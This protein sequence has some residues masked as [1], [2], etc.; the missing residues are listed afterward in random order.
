MFHGI[1][2]RANDLGANPYLTFS[3]AACVELIC[4]IFTFKILQFDV[5]RK[6]YFVLML[7]CG[8]S[9]TAIYFSSK[10][11]KFRLS[12]FSWTYFNLII[13]ENLLLTVLSALIAKFSISAS[14]AIV[15]FYSSELFN[16]SLRARYLSN[17]SLMARVGS[18][19]APFIIGV[20]S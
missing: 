9:C 1:G 14:Y 6:L 7:L 12:A 10:F 19:I 18:V 5:R 17:C 13:L 8:V 3:L 16:E 15:R 20:V 4:S 2:L 11:V